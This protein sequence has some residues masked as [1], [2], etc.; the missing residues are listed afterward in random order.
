M[1]VLVICAVF[2]VFMSVVSLAGTATNTQNKQSAIFEKTELNH[3]PSAIEYVP[4]EI[5][6]KF[7][8]GVR[9]DSIDMMNSE[10]GI[11]VKSTLLSGT[12]VL[13]VPSGKTADEM[14]RIYESLPEVEYVEPNYIAH[15]FMVPNDP[16]YSYQ[17]HLDND[18]Y[19]GINMESAWDISTGTGVVVAVLDT[20]VAY[21]NYSIYCQAPDLAGTTFVAGYDFA[22]NDAH[23]N[24]D[25]GH[26]THVTGTIAQTTNNNYGVAGVA[27][28]CS[29]MPVK[30]LNE[31]GAGYYSWIADG[32]YYAADNG[33]DIISM[34]LGGPDP[35]QTL[36]DA[37]TYAYNNGVMV[38]RRC[39]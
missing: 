12:K 35:S 18:D 31:T 15:V 26:G 3:A 16:Y 29:I 8:F 25:Q 33:A 34:S 2:L 6:V 7:K 5:L 22:N 10:Y 14:V 21:E 13:N 19:G 11:S 20:G 37:V 23:P 30:V 4:D 39:R 9:E 27:F 17:W 36:E 24:D 38:V 32:I 28:D 1:I